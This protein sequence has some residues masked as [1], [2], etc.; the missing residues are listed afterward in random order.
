MDFLNYTIPVNLFP[1]TWLMPDGAYLILPL[2][3]RDLA[4]RTGVFT[5]V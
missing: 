1:L 3:L 4:F 5:D 2:R